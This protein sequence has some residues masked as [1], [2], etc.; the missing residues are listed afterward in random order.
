MRRWGNEEGECEEVGER[1]GGVR[2]WG[3]EEWKGE[4][5]CRIIII[6]P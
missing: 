5:K 1:G 2:R 6:T 3:N 4:R